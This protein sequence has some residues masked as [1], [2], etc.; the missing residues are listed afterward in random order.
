MQIIIVHNINAVSALQESNAKK[1][2]NKHQGFTN[3][4]KIYIHN[5]ETK[6]IKKFDNKLQGCM[7]YTK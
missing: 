6:T 7:K 2:G 3:H 5:M 1:F 4:L